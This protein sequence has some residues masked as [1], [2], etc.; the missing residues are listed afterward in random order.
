MIPLGDGLAVTPPIGEVVTSGLTVNFGV[1]VTLLVGLDSLVA[2]ADGILVLVYAGVVER[3]PVGLGP[4]EGVIVGVVE[5]VGATVDV[6]V[7]VTIGASVVVIVGVKV[8][9]GSGVSVGALV[10][11]FVAGG[12][13]TVKEPLFKLTSIPPPLESV[14]AALLN[15]SGDVPGAALTNTLK[16]TF[17]TVP[18]GI[19]S[20]LKPKMITLTVLED[21]FDQLKFFPAEEAADP[22]LTLLTLKRLS[23]K[24]RSKFNPTTSAP[25]CELRLTGMMMF[26]SP[27]LPEPV[28]ADITAV[29]V[30]A[31]AAPKGTRRRTA[32]KKDVYTFIFMRVSLN[33]QHAIY[34]FLNI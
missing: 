27:G 1:G 24:L 22:I 7:E 29:G 9:V 3:P 33:Y 32:N 30:S 17:A 18:L 14:A 31:K 23:S 11:V 28:P 8:E 10:G 19:A 34:N 16:I 12:E 5:E 21:G 25:S 13:S 20:W 2:L 6:G 4:I 26:V 15:V